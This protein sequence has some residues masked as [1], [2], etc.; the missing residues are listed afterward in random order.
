MFWNIT[1]SFL[2]CKLTLQ[3]QHTSITTNDSPPSVITLQ[4]MENQ[5]INKAGIIKQPN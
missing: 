3:T 5:A 4:I 2:L 1:L